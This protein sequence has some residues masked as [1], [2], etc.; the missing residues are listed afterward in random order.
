MNLLTFAKIFLTVCLLLA[1]ITSC[2]FWQSVSN[3]NSSVI[4]PEEKKTVSG[5]PF[6]IQEP[7]NYLAEIVVKANDEEQKFFV[8]RKGINRLIK[9][10]VGE[11]SEFTIVSNETKS[12]LINSEKMIYAE[13]EIFPDNKFGESWFDFLTNENLNQK[14]DL[15]FESLGI[16]NNFSKYR[17][18]SG[19]TEAFIWIDETTKLPMKQEFLN[20]QKQTEFT[21]EIK[22]IKFETE[23][24]LFE[25]P[26]EYKKLSVKEFQEIIH[27]ADNN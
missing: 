26:K 5:F 10:D 11:K 18:I 15:S 17:I 21:I 12:Y 13:N 16:E 4:Q 24:N 8:A 1:T 23:L 20:L 14:N 27:N 3:S 2:R 25:I 6:S 7:S 9:Y 19:E 22:N